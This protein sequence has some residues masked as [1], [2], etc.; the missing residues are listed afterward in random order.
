MLLF[1]TFKKLANEELFA[2]KKE[3]KNVGYED[4]KQ[5]EKKYTKVKLH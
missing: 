4:K 1:K 3:T 5:E 2:L